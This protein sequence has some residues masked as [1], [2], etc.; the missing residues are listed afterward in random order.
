MA[1]HQAQTA[2][3]LRPKRLPDAHCTVTNMSVQQQPNH[4]KLCS[5]SKRLF[6]LHVNLAHD[7]PFFTVHSPCKESAFSVF[8]QVVMYTWAVLC[9]HTAALIR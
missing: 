2:A 4:T 5:Q 7:S 6:V 9:Q 3:A 8:V 1:A